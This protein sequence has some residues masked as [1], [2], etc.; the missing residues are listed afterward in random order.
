MKEFTVKNNTTNREYKVCG[1]ENNTIDTVWLSQKCWFSYGS[2]ITIANDK[3]ESK[4]F[5]KE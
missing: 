1:N 2:S 5:I 4:T 3:G